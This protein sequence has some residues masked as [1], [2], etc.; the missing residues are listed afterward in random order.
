MQTSKTS[1]LYGLSMHGLVERIWWTFKAVEEARAL[2]WVWEELCG[3][4]LFWLR[5]SWFGVFSG[6]EGDLRGSDS[7]TMA[8]VRTTSFKTDSTISWAS[9]WWERREG[10]VN[11]DLGW[12]FFFLTWCLCFLILLWWS[13]GHSRSKRDNSGVG[14]W[15][16]LL[17]TPS[18]T[19]AV[20][21][22]GGGTLGLKTGFWLKDGISLDV[23]YIRRVLGQYFL[24]FGVEVG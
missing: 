9:L 10:E 19:W 8:A 14:K 21:H 4:E 17:K 7:G 15:N 24:W 3:G 5:S 18:L 1:R 2:Y 23:G 20:S 11:G 13:W 16:F 12:C 6:E 22:G